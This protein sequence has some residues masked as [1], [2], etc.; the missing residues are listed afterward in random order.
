MKLTTLVVDGTRT[1]NPTVDDE[2]AYHPHSL[3]ALPIFHRTGSVLGEGELLNQ[4]D[5]FTTTD[6]EIVHAFTTFAT[7]ALQN[8]RMR[9]VQQTGRINAEMTKLVA[10]PE[11]TA[12]DIPAA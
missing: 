4:A 10:A 6:L 7:I 12:Y 5:G 9:T 8:W 1:L 3:V 2:S 11:C